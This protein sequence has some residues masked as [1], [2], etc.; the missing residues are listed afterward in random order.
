MNE[1]MLKDFIDGVITAAR[2]NLREDGSLETTAFIVRDKGGVSILVFPDITNKTK[3]TMLR[4]LTEHGKDL[5]VSAVILLTEAY[6]RILKVDDPDFDSYI[7]GKKDRSKLP[8]KEVVCIFGETF[9]GARVSCSI[10]RIGDAL[11]DEVEWQFGDATEDMGNFSR[12]F[13]NRPEPGTSLDIYG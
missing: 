5:T 4:V 12:F 13:R 7:S 3:P 2:L 6:S 9:D 8:S 10:D 11:S 1:D